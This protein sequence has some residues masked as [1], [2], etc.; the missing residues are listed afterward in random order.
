MRKK[1]QREDQ[2]R[3]VTGLSNG[4]VC[5]RTIIFLLLFQFFILVF[6]QT[7]I[8]GTIKDRLWPIIQSILSLEPKVK[9]NPGWG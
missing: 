9:Q 7:T 4:L 6:A 3:F 8:M 5:Q 2:K 1:M